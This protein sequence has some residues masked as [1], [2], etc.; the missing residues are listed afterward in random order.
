MN[1]ID[2]SFLEPAWE[3]QKAISFQGCI[4]C[5]VLSFAIAHGQKDQIWITHH[6]HPNVIAVALL[7][8]LAAVVIVGGGKPDSETVS[9][10]EEERIPLFITG[11]QAYDVVK[12]IAAH[13]GPLAQV[14]ADE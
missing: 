12:V 11:K 3:C 4:I 10:A 5:D 6:I 8:E 7:K 9:R 13:D 14:S 1:I 2:M